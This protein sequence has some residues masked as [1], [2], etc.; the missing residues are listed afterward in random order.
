MKVA[1]LLG[2]YLK[3]EGVIA[4]A[5]ICSNAQRA[6]LTAELL[7]NQLEFNIDQIQINERLYEASIREF[8]D[9][10]SKLYN[11]YNSVL[12]VGHNPTITHVADFLS[13]TEINGMSPGAVVQIN[14]DVESW[15]LISKG[16]GEFINYYDIPGEA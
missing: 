9:F 13:N 11:N 6:Q 10:L 12:I 5:L 14:F 1:S 15:D 2:K 7:A 3:D 4:D 16:L 8:V